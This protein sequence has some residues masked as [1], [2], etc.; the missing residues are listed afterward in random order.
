MSRPIPRARAPRSITIAVLAFTLI[1]A[2]VATAAVAKTFTLNVAKHAKVTNM[3]TG[4]T[5][6]PN[7]V[8]NKRGF[9][10]YTLTGDSRKHPEC[11]SALC[12][13]FWP[14][15]TVKSAK[16]LTRAPG[17]KGKLSTWRH[18]GFT[19]VM[20][21]GHPLYTFKPDSKPRVATGEGIVNFGGTWHV[22]M[23]KPASS[24][25]P[26]GS[27]TPTPWPGGY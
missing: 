2:A 10:L 12:R 1:G 24:T 9:V 3:V 5:T 11:L 22:R 27:G 4:K 19:Q 17:V 23:A 8:V 6:H 25:S 16:A 20:L 13:S 21:D 14:P 7:V 15:V 26:S 18:N